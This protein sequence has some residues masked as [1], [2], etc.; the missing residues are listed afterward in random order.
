ME[1]STATAK[2]AEDMSLHL[3]VENQSNKV[4]YAESGKAFVDV[5]FFFLQIPLGSLV[6]ILQEN[7]MNLSS[8]LSRVFESVRNLKPTHFLSQ[9]VQE[10]L[11]KPEV[12]SPTSTPPLLQSF[13][14][15]KQLKSETS[16][17]TLSSP[18]FGIPSSAPAAAK[19]KAEVGFVKEGETKYIVMDDLRVLPLSSIFL[20]DLFKKFNVK[21]TSFREV[22]ININKCLEIVKASLESD[23][24]LTDVF[25]G[26]NSEENLNHKDMKLNNC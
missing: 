12:A 3:L 8:S 16:P 4:L 25:I 13:F 15:V 22:K 20:V 24:V 9:T 17:A 21:D 14:P 5:L 1:G 6:G 26:K 19:K 18:V 23:A 11:L 10:S 2:Q 7:D